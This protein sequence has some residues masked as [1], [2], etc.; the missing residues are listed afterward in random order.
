MGS[1]ILTINGGS[2]SVKFALFSNTGSLKREL[3]GSIQRIGLPGAQLTIKGADGTDS[4]DQTL[5]VSNHA[6][7]GRLVIDALRKRGL[8][9]TIGA[10]GHRIVHGGPNYLD[11]AKIDA[12]M[13]EELRRVSPID[14]EH[15]PSE[16]K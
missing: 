8:I 2:S 4:G 11:H 12:K 16:M 9:D 7:A 10:V 15:L 6:D 5:S 14:P 1:A 13:L 3:T